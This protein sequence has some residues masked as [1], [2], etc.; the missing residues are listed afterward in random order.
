[1]P[2]SASQPGYKQSYVASPHD[3]HRRPSKAPNPS[4]LL[5]WQTRR[6]AVRKLTAAWNVMKEGLLGGKLRL[7]P[8]TDLEE[9]R[10]Q[11]CML[12]WI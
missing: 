3:L 9:A 5:S 6:D 1:M 8:R 11:C 7:S 12:D 10:S 2:P 4:M